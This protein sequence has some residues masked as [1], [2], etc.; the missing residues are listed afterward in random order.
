M[1][2]DPADTCAAAAGLVALGEGAVSGLAQ[3]ETSLKAAGN[4]RAKQVVEALR[5]WAAAN[6]KA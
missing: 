1:L 2:D 5:P 6:G 4:T 3:L